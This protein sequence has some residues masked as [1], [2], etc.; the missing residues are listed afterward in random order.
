MIKKINIIFQNILINLNINEAI[1]KLN[2]KIFLIIFQIRY[3]E[4]PIRN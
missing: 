3:R 2:T 4:T 1:K